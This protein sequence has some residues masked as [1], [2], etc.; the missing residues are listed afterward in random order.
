M[1]AKY[2]K[3]RTALREQPFAFSISGSAPPLHAP[4]TT[5]R[6]ALA[7]N[8]T[9]HFNRGRSALW[10]QSIRSAEQHCGNSHLHFRF[11]GVLRPYML[12][13]PQIAAPLPLTP[14]CTS[15]E[16][17]ALCGSKVSEVPNNDFGNSHFHFRF[18][19]VLRPYMLRI[20][21]IAAP[22]LL[23][24]PCTS[25][26][27]GALCGSKVSEVPNSDCG[28]SHFHFRFP[29]VLRPYMLRIPQIAAPL[30]LTPPCTSTEGGALYGSKVSEVP[31]GVAGTVI[32]IFDFRECS[33]PTCSEYH[34]SQRP[35]C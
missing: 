15:T 33:A 34:K 11:P 27:G 17:G 5:N 8:T 7:A 4:D 35:C 14:P 18:P 10:E 26:E 29:G 28:N 1:G 20:P 23:T 22:L 2:P 12:R 25:T 32:C 19:G 31:N 6:S 13:I 21:Q 16:G 24:P 30:L 3:C 9:V